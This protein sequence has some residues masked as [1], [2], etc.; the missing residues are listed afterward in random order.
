[1]TIET[2]LL[3]EGVAAMSLA[4]VADQLPNHALTV[5]RPNG[6]PEPHDH[7]LGFWNTEGTDF[8]ASDARASWS[9]WS[10]VTHETTAKLSSTEHAYHV[11]HKLAY[12]DRCKTVAATH[13]VAFATEAN[14]ADADLVFDS[15]PPR[16]SP[17]A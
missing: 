16:A 1:M 10:V 11:M 2:V 9:T 8:A 14:H 7:M 5:V 17:N 3:G 12:L 6:A 15:R 13:G 4:S